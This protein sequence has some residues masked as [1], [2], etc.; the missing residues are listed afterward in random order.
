MDAFTKNTDVPDHANIYYGLIST[1]AR[2]AKTATYIVLTL[3][4]DAVFVSR[5]FQIPIRSADKVAPTGLPRLCRLGTRF[6][7]HVSP[8]L[9]VDCRHR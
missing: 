1:S 7:D 9:S 5:L 2:I 6:L 8:V 3:V 4:S